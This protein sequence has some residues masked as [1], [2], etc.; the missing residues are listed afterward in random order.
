M[1]NILL[2]G[3]SHGIGLEI[4]T[5]MAPSAQLFVASRTAPEKSHENI[6]HIP[7]DVLS[8]T[9]DMTLMP[10][11][12]DGFVYC[13]GSINLKPLK[14][15]SNEAFRSD[16]E[17]NFFAMLPI[18]QSIMPRMSLG[19]S[20]VYF[21]TVAVGMGMPFHA[22]IA[23]A[24]GAVEGFTKSLAAEYAPKI[25]VNCIAPSLT[26]TPLAGRL[27]NNEKKREM[28]DARHPLK[29]VGTPADI[30]Q[31]AVFLLSDQSSWMSGQILG[32]DG[33]MSSLNVH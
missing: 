16:M 22:S 5:L 27:L 17:I 21:S 1:K 12:I 31:M 14:M 26:D 19:S 2:I 8:D 28:M 7:F 20:I 4:I 24:K 32:V 15:L 25:R 10:E 23:A 33:G 6:T 13:P 29:R 18:V 3:G 30:A 9:L 11:Q